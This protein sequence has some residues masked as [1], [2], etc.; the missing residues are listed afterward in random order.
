MS[1]PLRLDWCSLDAARFACERWHYSGSLPMPPR[2]NIGVWEGGRFIGVVMFSRGAS[3]KLLNPYGLKQDEGC[4]LTRVALT[5]HAAPVS[6]IVAIAIRIL[7]RHSPGMRLIVS[8]ADPH[9]GHHGGIYQAGGWV[10]AGTTAATKQFIGPDGKTYHNRQ[11]AAADPSLPAVITEFGKSNRVYRKSE[12]TVIKLPPKHRYLLPLD[13]SLRERIT[14][15][16]QPYPKRAHSESG[17]CERSG[18]RVPP[19][20]GRRDSD[21]HAPPLPLQEAMHHEP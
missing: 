3:A 7:S 8:F 17:A 10:Y 5:K 14:A 6:R 9:E 16:A 12:C 1:E 2:V 11:V 4:E 19:G 18:D 20:S 13:P 15:L 21:P